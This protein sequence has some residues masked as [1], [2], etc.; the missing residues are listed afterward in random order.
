MVS[1]VDD[2]VWQKLVH[3]AV[4]NPVS[5][6]TGMSCS[7]LLEDDDMQA[8]M[9]ATR[10]TLSSKEK[11]AFRNVQRAANRWTYLGSGM[12]HEAFLGTLERLGADVQRVVAAAPRFGDAAG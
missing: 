1:R 12:T 11:T 4:V 6:L 9:R 3:N 7:E 5:A 2:V 10:R 8:F